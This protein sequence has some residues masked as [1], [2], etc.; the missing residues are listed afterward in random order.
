VVLEGARSR[1][2]WLFT[3]PGGE[4]LRRV[5]PSVEAWR[6]A[7]ATLPAGARALAIVSDDDRLLVHDLD[8]AKD[9]RVVAPAGSRAA[10]VNAETVLIATVEGTAA[11]ELRVVSLADGSVRDRFSLGA[12]EPGGVE[13]A[14]G[15]GSALVSWWRA[16]EGGEPPR[17]VA[18][19]IDLRTH[20][21]IAE[22]ERDANVFDGGIDPTG[23]RILVASAAGGWEVRDRDGGTW[24]A[25]GDDGFGGGAWSGGG[26]YAILSA[27]G[28][29]TVHE[30]RSGNALWDDLLA[31]WGTDE[32]DRWLADA[33]EKGR[34]RVR[35]L[36]TGE[37]VAELDDQAGWPEPG[38]L[39]GHEVLRF[40][41][42]G[43][44]LLVAGGGTLLKAWRWRDAKPEVRTF[45]V[46]GEEPPTAVALADAGTA[47]VVEG[48]GGL[49]R[50]DLA[51][52][53]RD[54]LGIDV[55]E[56]G[57]A[58]SVVAAGG[59]V[60]VGTK[61]PSGNPVAHVWDLARGARVGELALDLVTLVG[62]IGTVTQS[63]RYVRVL[64]DETHLVT[65]QLDAGTARI[66][67]AQ[68]LA[69][70]A[71]AAFAE[72]RPTI[73]VPD[74]PGQPRAA[75]AAS[76][77]YLA[78]AALD[79]A[80]HVVGVPGGERLAR[81]EHPHEGLRWTAV[82]TDGRH[83]VSADDAHLVL[84]DVAASRATELLG[85][86]DATPNEACFVGD[87]LV[88]A[89][90]DGVVRVWTAATGE[91]ARTLEPD[92]LAGEELDGLGAPIDSLRPRV[93]T[94]FV[95]LGVDPSAR[96]VAALDDGGALCLWS[97]ASGE[98]VLRWRLPADRDAR[99]LVSPGG[100]RL[101][102]E[103]GP[104]GWTVIDLR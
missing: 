7:A 13:V 18:T 72:P 54:P 48:A 66:W 43:E 98:Q 8:A 100:D 57:G 55:T 59:R 67:R 29:T 75:L 52:G 79:G 36:R 69:R 9:I 87:A 76:G 42:D 68:D 90:G 53:R 84:W 63:P 83:A 4:R 10:L 102:V 49:A 92:L 61:E 37:V 12:G 64:A 103:E 95:A 62:P 60:V 39:P 17:A 1:E 71:T 85:P 89:C 19:W 74:E 97:L 80:V 65:V 21:V 70:V 44:T 45:L 73:D 22:V 77:R 78:V 20:A 94:G 41:P 58:W 3:F 86:D 24:S 104:R 50:V 27:D 46:G 2:T 88:A 38:D 47:V 11:G 23:T 28:R 34:V 35:A 26:G 32:G 81:L 31:S 93:R 91:L 16:G 25:P 33:D 96:W 101:V 14:R 6:A 15:G 5:Q 56:E 40:T 99:L 51:A 82:S 30:A